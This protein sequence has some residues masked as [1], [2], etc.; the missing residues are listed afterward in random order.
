VVNTS[1]TRVERNAEAVAHQQIV[2]RSADMLRW[3]IDNHPFGIYVLDAQLR[4]LHAS[5]DARRAFANNLPLI[6]CDFRETVRRVWPE[7]FAT[8]VLAIFERTLITGESYVSPVT[9]ER[10]LDLDEEQAYDWRVDRVELPEGGHGLVCSFYDLSERRRWEAR[11]EQADRHKEQFLA[12]LSHELRN[13]LA[14]IRTAAELLESSDLTS[15]HVAHAR[16]VIVRQVRHMARLLDDLLDV[17][18]IGQDKLALQVERGAVEPIFEEAIEAVRPLID[19]LQHQLEVRLP[20][21]RVWV[22]T[23]AVRLAQVISNLLT[24]AAK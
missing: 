2:R 10:R 20:A 4:F 6:G 12:T 15:E 14:P 19:S 3:L 17:A 16:Q 5:K 21:A 13:P 24:N 1:T 7:P 23:D 9:V 11:L 22:E 18:R 8:N